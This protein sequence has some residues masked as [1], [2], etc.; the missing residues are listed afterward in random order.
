MGLLFIDGDHSYS[1]ARLDY[2]LWSPKLVDGGYI[3]LH[4]TIRWEGPRRV[5]EKFLFRSG[6]FRGI[7]L[8]DSMTWA[9][10]VPTLS[11]VQR[12]ANRVGLGRRRLYVLA[13]RRC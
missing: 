8:T 6:Q 7:H 9:C 10:K 5:V 3:A 1:A 2:E 12:S 11:L 4:D 13:R